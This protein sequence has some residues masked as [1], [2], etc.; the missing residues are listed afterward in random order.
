MD[1][2][3]QEITES[4]ATKFVKQIKKLEINI[5]PKCIKIFNSKHNSVKDAYFLFQECTVL[6][7][8]Y[9]KPVD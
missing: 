2:S 3:E 4:P 5:C 7:A 9:N 8:S 1:I 6:V